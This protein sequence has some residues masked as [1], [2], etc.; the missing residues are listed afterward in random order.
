MDNNSTS[1]W[2]DNTSIGV[3]TTL[4]IDFVGAFLITL[5]WLLIRWCRG[6]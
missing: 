6:D 2:V 3:V 1:G 5:I 4:G